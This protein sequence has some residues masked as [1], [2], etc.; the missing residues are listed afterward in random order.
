M[1]AST[2]ILSRFQRLACPHNIRRLR[3]LCLLLGSWWLLLSCAGQAAVPTGQPLRPTFD[4]ARTS[5]NVVQILRKEAYRK[6]DLKS[7]KASEQLFD[8]YIEVL[9]K[10]R[11]FFLASDIETDSDTPAAS[12]SPGRYRT[13]LAGDL[14]RGDLRSAFAIHERYRKRRGERL[15]YFIAL[16]EQGLDA[17]DFSRDETLELNREAAPWPAS[18]AAQKDLWRRQLKDL[19]LTMKLEEKKESGVAEFLIR[20]FKSQQRHLEQM[21]SEDVLQQYMNGYTRLFDPHTQYFSPQ[22]A[23]NFNMNMSL[24]MEG[25]G[26]VLQE[27]DEYTKVVSLVPAGPA[28]RAGQLKPGDRIVAVSQEKGPMIDVVGMRLDDV[29][30][31]IRGEKGTRVR[32]K[33]MP[34]GVSDSKGNLYTIVR[35]KVRLEEQSARKTVLDLDTEY[36]KRRIGV[37]TIPAFYLD[38]I[39]AMQNKKDYKSTTRDV[40]RLLM[41]LKKE[42]IDALVVDLR[43]NNGG[44]LQ[45]ANQLIG[46]FVPEGPTVFVRNSD[47]RVSIERDKDPE[48]LY[49]GPMAVLINRLSA[50][51][52]EIFAGAMQ[53]Y[54][55]ALIVGDQSFGKGTVQTLKTLKHGQLKLTVAQ[56]FRVSGQSPQYQGVQPDIGFPSLFSSADIGE[57]ALHRAQPGQARPESE[58]IDPRRWVDASAM[59]EMDRRK[60]RLMSLLPALRKRHQLRVANNPEFLYLEKLLEYQK[61]YGN[62]TLVQLNEKKR[63]AA[64]AEMRNERLAIENWWRKARGKKAWPNFE[65]F[66]KDDSGRLFD[67]GPDQEA[68]EDPFLVETGEVLADWIRETGRRRAEVALRPQALPAR[69]SNF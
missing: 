19:V 24:S 8:S 11:S 32:L 65:A 28:D 27:D 10:N 26:A 20:R 3:V 54:G 18:P 34:A 12:E 22:K 60:K 55:R 14:S 6:L 29:V 69:A 38:F 21:H 50:S 66:A 49:Q 42:K 44:S 53:D 33:V 48:I 63:M 7:E 23:E 47:G 67:S 2:R 43:S 40:R 15:A 68:S 64:L 37:I 57:K 45:E 35:D 16:L 31:L 36:G 25:I 52:S 5:F 30:R 56:F 41:E 59:G 58:S 17:M 1:R 62:R 9:D 51:S 46:L 4:L 61:K 39:A 13:T